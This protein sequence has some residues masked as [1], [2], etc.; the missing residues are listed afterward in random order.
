[1]YA[2]QEVARRANSQN[3]IRLGGP[4]SYYNL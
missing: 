3:V 4:Y 2:T 1:M